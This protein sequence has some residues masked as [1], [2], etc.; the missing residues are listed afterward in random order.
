MEHFHLRL[1]MYSIFSQL[2][3]SYSIKISI[4]LILFQICPKRKSKRATPTQVD[5]YMSSMKA[6]GEQ[7]VT[8]LKRIADSSE[9]IAANFNAN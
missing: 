5:D 3:R 4:Y 1:F 9:H 7:I 2:H 8:A 6:I